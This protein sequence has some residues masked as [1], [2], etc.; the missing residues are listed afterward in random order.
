M[1]WMRLYIQCF[2]FQLV[3]VHFFFYSYRSK[4]LDWRRYS[5]QRFF[6]FS[7]S[8]VSL[9]FQCQSLMDLR[10]DL[11]FCDQRYFYE[12]RVVFQ[13]LILSRSLERFSSYSSRRCFLLIMCCM[14]SRALFLRR[15]F[16]SSQFLSFWSRLIF[17]WESSRVDLRESV[18]WDL[19]MS[20]SFFLL[21]YWLRDYIYFLSEL[22]VCQSCLRAKVLRSVC[23]FAWRRASRRELICCRCLASWDLSVYPFCLRAFNSSSF[24]SLQV[25]SSSLSLYFS[26]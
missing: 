11:V 9:S 25:S 1:V 17:Q 14:D 5:S 23:E 10:S 16:I 6:F 3:E 7:Q 19:S 24:F 26:T 22:I 18:Q 21:S 15:S 2:S 12:R 20:S 4:L 13:S 8:Y